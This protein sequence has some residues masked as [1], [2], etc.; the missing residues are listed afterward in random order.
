MND[1]E[2]VKISKFLNLELRLSTNPQN[3]QKQLDNPKF[4][5]QAIKAL[6]AAQYFD[7]QKDM[8]RMRKLLCP[9]YEELFKGVRFVKL[10]QAIN[11][12]GLF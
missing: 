6:V 3:N 12:K 2:L 11:C 7:K 1:S 4:H 5:G 8:N 10:E 9:L